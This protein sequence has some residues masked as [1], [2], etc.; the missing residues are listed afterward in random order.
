MVILH[1][2]KY[3]RFE[4]KLLQVLHLTIYQSCGDI[5]G[6]IHCP[7]LSASEQAWL[8]EGIF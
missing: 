7:H 1:A 8:L 3:D 5:V 2:D 4:M 6:S